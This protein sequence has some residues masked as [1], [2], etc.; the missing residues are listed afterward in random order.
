MRKGLLVVVAVLAVPAIAVGQGT[1]R[2]ISTGDDFF[3]PENVSAEFG[4]GSFHWAWATDNQHN[5]RQD[6]RLFYSGAA[7]ENGEFAVTP[8]AGSFHYYCELHGFDGGGMD[9]RLKVKPVA[10]V[11]GNRATLTWASAETNSGIQFD[12]RQKTGSSKPR[13]VEEKTRAFDGTFK[14]KPGANT[15]QVRSRRAKAAS[16]WSPKLKLQP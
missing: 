2:E 5:I 12:V 6:D 10:S 8:S 9:G 3:E 1:T 11:S 16:D 15:F 7:V 14:L 4:A 13:L